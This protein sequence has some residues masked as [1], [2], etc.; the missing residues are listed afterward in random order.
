MFIAENFINDVALYLG[1]D[2]EK[3]RELN[4]LKKGQLTHCNQVIESTSMNDCW[5]Q[6]L[7][8]SQFHETREEIK[9]FNAENKWKKRGISIIPTN[10]GI[11]FEQHLNQGGEYTQ[12][13]F[14]LVFLATGTGT[15]A[16]K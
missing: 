4:L 11:A 3:L 15:G 2:P 6:C 16:G 8:Q 13:G 12:A 5:S 7:K 1:K 9:K 14:P 10:F